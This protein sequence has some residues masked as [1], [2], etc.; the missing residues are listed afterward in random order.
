[1]QCRN[2]TKI[3][4]PTDHSAKNLRVT[5]SSFECQLDCNTQFHRKRCTLTY[6]CLVIDSFNSY[7]LIAYTWQTLPIKPLQAW[8]LYTA[9]LKWMLRRPKEC[10]KV[11]EANTNTCTVTQPN[12]CHPVSPQKER[13]IS[14]CC[15]TLRTME[16][17]ASGCSGNVELALTSGEAGNNNNRHELNSLT[18]L[19]PL[20]NP[21]HW[22][23]GWWEN[24]LCCPEL[25]HRHFTVS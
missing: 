5:W 1:M 25:L 10:G 6:E 12:S 13:C 14:F 8:I 23:V 16:Q 2:S 7:L 4:S 11:P 15:L 20:S 18:H 22:G 24:Q 3:I 19:S 21:G 9:M 17:L